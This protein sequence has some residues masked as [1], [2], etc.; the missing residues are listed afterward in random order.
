V[1]PSGLIEELASAYI[2]GESVLIIGESGT[3]KSTLQMHALSA[4]ALQVKVAYVDNLELPIF[5]DIGKVQVFASIDKLPDNFANANVLGLYEL[6]LGLRLPIVGADIHP[7]YE[8]PLSNLLLSA[9]HAGI[10]TT[11]TVPLIARETPTFEAIYSNY[12]ALFAET[13]LIVAIDREWPRFIY[14][15]WRR[16]KELTSK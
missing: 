8:S 15:F 1:Y 2:A 10:G 12:P 6:R 14:R 11:T 7:V 13:S 9:R 5:R 3:G 16:R 4:A